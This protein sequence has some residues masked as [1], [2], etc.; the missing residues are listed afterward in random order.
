M[1]ILFVSVSCKDHDMF[2]SLVVNVT[3]ANLPNPVAVYTV[4]LFDPATSYT[5]YANVLYEATLVD[6]TAEFK[7]VNP[8][9]Y[10]VLIEYTNMFHAAQVRGGKTT[11]VKVN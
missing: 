1:L 5:N 3:V 8:G 7:D 6:G 4:G 10:V 2:G 9:N 11:S